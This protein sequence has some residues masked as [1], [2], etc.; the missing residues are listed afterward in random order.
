MGIPLPLIY[1]KEDDKGVYIIVDGRQRLTTL[2]QFMSHEFPLQN[3]TVLRDLNGSYFS[4]L[5]G[6]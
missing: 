6:P 1:V 3:L 4:E 5:C 2:F